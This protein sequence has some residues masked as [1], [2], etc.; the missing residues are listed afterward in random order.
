MSDDS[1]RIHHL[2]LVDVLKAMGMGARECMVED[3]FGIAYCSDVTV[4]AAI[5]DSLNN[6]MEYLVQ[7]TLKCFSFAVALAIAERHNK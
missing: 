6:N 5:L 2:F 7:R 4:R 1:E 3:G